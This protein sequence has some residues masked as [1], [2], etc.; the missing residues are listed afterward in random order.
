MAVTS[1]MAMPSD[2]N[3]PMSHMPLKPGNKQRAEAEERRQR[4]HDDRLAGAAGEDA[5]LSVLAVAVDNVDA[6]RHVDA[7]D[8]RQRDDVR[9]IEFD[10]EPDHRTGA[11]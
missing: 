9:G 2:I 11:P 8:E 7:D 10:A 3:S 1:P 6:E 5:E 4:R